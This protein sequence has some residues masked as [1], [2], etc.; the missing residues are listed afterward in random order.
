[1]AVIRQMGALQI[2]TISVVARSPYLVLWSRLGDYQPP[3]LDDLLTE[4]ALFES[5]AHAICWI[6]IEDFPLYRRRMLDNAHSFGDNPDKWLEEHRE[7]TEMVLSRIRQEGGLRSSDFE[8]KRQHSNG[9]WDWKEEKRVLEHLFNTGVLMIARRN[10]FQRVYDLR[11]RVYPDWDDANTPSVEVVR[12]ELALKSIRAM[13][14]A[15]AGWVANYFYY[16]SKRELPALLKLLVDQGEVNVVEVEGWTEPAYVHPDNLSWLDA[17]ASQKLKPTM[18]TLLS[19]FDPLIWDRGR[20]K[21]MFGFDYT[22]G[23]YTPA[24]KRTYGYFALPILYQGKLV[25]RL[26]A[27]AHRAVKKFEVKD[28]W[29]EPGYELKGA[30]AEELKNTLQTCAAWH[31]TPEVVG[32]RND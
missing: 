20:V 12:R 23:C 30:L 29:M 1:M 25:G 11:E 13:G 16:L 2:D 4:G 19:P 28:L 24:A 9:W 8:N 5:W 10:K 3:W 7:M 22:I 27:K 14:I 18:T 32:L 31:G 26:D 21:V 15:R 17:A 6:S